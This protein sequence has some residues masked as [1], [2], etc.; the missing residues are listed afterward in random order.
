MLHKCAVYAA[1]E[2]LFQLDN[3]NATVR[4]LVRERQKSA[5]FSLLDRHFG[6]HRYSRPSRHHRQ[7][8]SELTA[9]NN[10]IRLHPGA[11]AGG[12]SVFAK[13]VA[14]LQQQKGIVRNLCKVNMG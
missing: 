10:Y 5:P 12:Q 9:L 8:G 14:L 1:A 2:M 6:H 4:T 13:A 3:S 7:D 11:S